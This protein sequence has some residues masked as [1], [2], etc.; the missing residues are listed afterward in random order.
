MG[1]NP[2]MD[3]CFYRLMVLR[4]Q[5]NTDVRRENTDVRWIGFHPPK[6]CH[7]LSHADALLKSD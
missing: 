3:I 4:Q 1:V 7:E 2:Y 5:L 6:N